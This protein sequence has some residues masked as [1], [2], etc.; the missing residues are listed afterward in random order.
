MNDG[1][2]SREDAWPGAAPLA[3][4]AALEEQL[5]ACTAELERERA[6]RRILDARLEPSEAALRRQL[7]ALQAD[8][9]Q[10]PVGLCALDTELRF[11]RI[12][13]SLAGLNG[14]PAADH[15]GQTVRE[16]VPGLADQV[17]PL[18]RQV[19]RTGTPALNVATIGDV[20]IPAWPISSTSRST[21]S[22][23]TVPSSPAWSNMTRTAPSSRRSSTWPGA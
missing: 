18:L 17:E 13:A 21:R 1:N 22:R 8:Y 20:A 6:A 23:S 12:N 2:P 10:A 5:K 4:L 3:R 19:L 16:M 11:Q 9:D 15:L 7:A 14:R